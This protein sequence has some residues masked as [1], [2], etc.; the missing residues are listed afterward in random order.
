MRRVALLAIALLALLPAAAAAQD[1]GL[2][3]KRLTK[4]IRQAGAYSSAYVVEVSGDQPR[5]IF[6]W[7]ETTPRILASNTKLFTTSAA[8]ARFG[9]EGTLATQVFGTGEL[10]TAGVYRGSIYLRGGGDP[11]FGSRRFATRS[12]GGGATVQDLA[13]ALDDAGIQ[14]V[15]GRVYGDESAFDSLRGGPDSGYGVSVWVGPLSGLSYNRGLFTEGGRGFQAN[16][17]AFAAARLDDALEA[18][19]IRVRLK[20]RAGVTPVDATLLASVDSP[21]MERLLRITNKPSDNFFAETLLKDLALEANGRGTTRAG[22]RV[23]AAFARGLGARATLVDGSGLSRG[24]RASPVSIVRL[25]TAM[26]AR[27]DFEPFLDS[28]PIAGRDGTLFDRMRRGPARDHCQGKTGTLSN[29]SALSGYCE[30]LSGDSYVF[31][32][33]MN[34][35]YP[36][37]ARRIQDRML[38]EIARLG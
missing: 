34:G 15:T 22:T 38:Q 14:R 25:L 17:P 11:T 23:A 18:R 31:S 27:G 21:P 28:L 24:N 9:S 2:L 3:V 30:T 36:T 32:I 20:P 26:R 12:Y 13:V 35:V 4:Q 33:L 7:R 16:P 29:V 1:E 5:A 6:R 8:L 19:Q 37:G 10:D